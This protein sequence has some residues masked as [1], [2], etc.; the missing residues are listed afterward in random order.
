MLFRPGPPTLGGL[1]LL[2]TGVG[3][4]AVADGFSLGVLEEDRSNYGRVMPGVVIERLSSTG[5]EGTRIVGGR[6]I[7]G[8]LVVRT[9]GFDPYST[10]VRWLS[11]GSPS[12][13]VVD[14][15]YGCGAGGGTC[16]GRDFVSHDLWLRLRTGA[17]V[18]VRRSLGEKS[19]SRLD[20]NPQWRVAVVTTAT[21]C[22]LLIAAALLSGRVKFRPL[23]RYIRAP[24][25]VTAV[26]E[27]Q[28]GDEKRWR[29]TFRYFDEHAAPQ[30]SVDEANDPTWRV[31]EAC[32]AVYRPQAPDVATLQ[33]LA[34]HGA[35]STERL[36]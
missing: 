24:A 26:H 16:F 8:R 21:G 9:S 13:Y 10:F 20:E 27:I 25:V 22:L 14:Y 4:F 11:S 36:A 33:P 35:E 12:A 19:T 2:L 7:R 28:Y 23:A 1:A 30:E 29:V 5:E 31:G 15:R 18:N 32:V 6:G 34:T 3:L 17:L